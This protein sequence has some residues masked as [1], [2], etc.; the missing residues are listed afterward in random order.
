[1]EGKNTPKKRKVS[2]FPT[3]L[4]IMLV[5]FLVGL[6]SLLVYHANQL[7]DYLK[8]NVQMSLLFTQDAKEPDILRMQKVFESKPFINKVEY[9]SREEARE[10]MQKDLGEEVTEILGYNPFP[11]SLDIYFTADFTTVDSLEKFKTS[12]ADNSSIREIFYQ[13]ALVANIDKNVR[14]AGAVILILMLLFLLIAIALINSTI[15]LNLYSK[16]FLIKSMQLVGA[17]QWFIRRPFIY[18]AV[19]NGFWGGIV[20]SGLLLI[21]LNLINRK[22]GIFLISDQIEVYFVIFVG[23]IL[24]GMII[25]GISSY[26]SVNKYLKLKLDDLY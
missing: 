14:I 8:E 21:L 18:K 11:P 10:M 17:T 24:L 5:L 20:A 3:F 19:V 6:F 4:S 1:M 13:K 25:T 26:F 22:F 15:R 12:L 2:Y 16:R 23:L 7:K 9:I